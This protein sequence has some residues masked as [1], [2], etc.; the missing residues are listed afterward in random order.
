MGSGLESTPGGFLKSLVDLGKPYSISFP[1]VET[2]QFFRDSNVELGFRPISEAAFANRH[3]LDIWWTK[4][5]EL[6]QIPVP[7]D[8]DPILDATR[9][10]FTMTKVATPDLKQSEA[11]LATAAL[12]HIFGQNSKEEKVHLKLP[13]VWRDFWGEL[14]EARKDELD[15]R[16]REVMRELRDFVRQRQD[17]ELE[18]GVILQG[19]FKGRN[20]GK[21]GGEN[22]DSII[23]HRSR[24]SQI[25]PDALRKI[26]A[27][28]SSTPQY[29]E[30]MASW[31]DFL[32]FPV[33]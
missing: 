13:P 30:M 28:K 3:A 4:P 2:N 33:Y 26:W 19:V 32:M 17:Q 20:A 23:A 6:P 5:Q 24:S 31:I 8:I 15:S 12:F 25:S 14:A 16:D 9:F 10:T 21:S 18:D 27:D 22:S 29:K 11:Y 1:Y 7:L